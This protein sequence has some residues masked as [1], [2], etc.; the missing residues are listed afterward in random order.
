MQMLNAVPRRAILCVEKDD[1]PRALLAQS[2]G[3]YEL[4]FTG[5]AFETI[6]SMHAR[7][8]DGYII[9]FWLPDWS[10][11]QLCRAIREID[12]HCPII[13]CTAA[14]GELSRQRA[15]R[16]GASAYL[17]KPVDVEALQAKLSA[18][19]ARTDASSLRAKAE[20]EHAVEAELTRWESRLVGSATPATVL[21]SVERSARARAYKTFQAAGGTRAHFER[22]WPHVFGSARANNGLVHGD[23]AVSLASSAS[24]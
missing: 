23:S 20:M 18:L 5:D 6:R 7:A 9:D 19:L 12:P 1:A 21:Q 17:S 3:E 13:F 14:E 4:V 10:G 11:P 8:F 22:W 24:N 2:L 15:L 16:A